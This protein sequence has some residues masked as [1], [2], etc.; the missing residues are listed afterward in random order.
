MF[1]FG[2]RIKVCTAPFV[3][4]QE[5]HFR[6]TCKAN[7]CMFMKISLWKF[8]FQRRRKLLTGGRL[9]V[10]KFLEIELLFSISILPSTALKLRNFPYNLDFKGKNVAK[11]FLRSHFLSVC[12]NMAVKQHIIHEPFK[13]YVTWIMAFFI[14]LTCVALYQC[15]LPC[16]IP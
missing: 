7:F 3:D 1:Q 13:K 14:P 4:P 16:V 15:S 12:N 9:N 8:L 2:V 10:L 11:F 6:S 5:L